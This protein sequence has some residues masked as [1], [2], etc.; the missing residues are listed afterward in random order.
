[1]LLP[2]RCLLALNPDNIDDWRNCHYR[3]CYQC[4]T[5]QRQDFVW[6]SECASLSPVTLGRRG[7]LRNELYDNL[8]R[9]QTIDRDEDPDEKPA[10]WHV[11]LDRGNAWYS[12]VFWDTSRLT[13]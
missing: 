12:R 2:P 3:C 8:D 6:Y 4:A 7:S 1:M 9:S 5:G 13:M 11:A 10:G